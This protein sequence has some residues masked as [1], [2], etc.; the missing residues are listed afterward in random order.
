MLVGIAAVVVLANAPY[1]LHIFDGN[2][3]GPRSQLTDHGLAGILDG[4]PT[5]DPN[6]GFTSQAL[7]HLAAQDW[8]HLQ[9]PWW[10]PYEGAGTALAGEMQSAA[11]FPPTLLLALAN[12]QIYEHVLF[13][14]VAGW[15]TYLL[16][17]RL[18]LRPCACVAGAIAFALNGTFA[19]LGN[20]AANPVALLPVLL[21]GIELAY[22]ATTAAKRGG[23]W[24]IAVAVALS[25]YAGFPE[26]AYIDG[27]FAAGWF[28]WRAAGA[29]GVDRRA[30]AL[31]GL[32][33]ALV[34]ALL[35]APIITA[36]ADFLHVGYTAGFSAHAGPHLEIQ[37]LPA[38]VLPYVYG[39]I[40]GLHDAKG[41]STGVWGGVGGYLTMSLVVFG[42]LGLVSHGRR[43]L[44][45]LLGVWLALA[46]ARMYGEP[47]ELGRVLGVLPGMS[48]VVFYRYATPAVE[49]AA[50]VLLALGVD[51]LA[52]LP[53][54]RRRAL[55]A[56]AFGLT[57]VVAAG[58]EARGL[59]IT[60]VGEQ[61]RDR[62]FRAAVVVGGA[63]VVLGVAAT[64]SRRPRLR[65]GVACGLVV[66]ETLAAFML[67]ELSAPRK[68]NTNFAAVDYLRGQ[69][70]LQRV[71]TLGPLQPNYG[72]YF[73]VAEINDDDLPI[74]KRWADYVS[75]SL[76]PTIKPLHFYGISNDPKT[77]K[78]QLPFEE[79]FDNLDGY[80]V[81]GVTFVI[82][83]AYVHL[84]GR[85]PKTF[86]KVFSARDATVYKVAGDEPY[87]TASGGAC[88]IVTESRQQLSLVCTRG[89][90]LIRR[91][92]NLPGWTARVD[93]ARTAI[94]AADGAF[95]AVDLSA[96]SH[97]VSFVYTPP[98]IRW[99]Y[100]AFI[101]GIAWLV[102][103]A[104]GR[105]LPL[106]RRRRRVGAALVAPDASVAAQDGVE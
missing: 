73:G 33:G 13:E 47:P 88:H 31:K 16:L 19:W 102:L 14:L 65:I 30:F 45:I 75:S 15:A 96:G 95:Q 9:I 93:G 11:L 7:G 5:I 50:V 27:V 55:A 23:W 22:A 35:A 56:A 53:S 70:G 59:V 79:L 1:L 91:E 72:S 60:L 82:T 2:P 89:S 43:G 32:A 64:L 42:G 99:A 28:I 61:T 97:R 69:I 86:T 4:M 37:A 94:H 101:A 40:F 48:S 3:L 90:V 46:I 34:G 92:T 54:G 103:G 51:C 20:A 38:L 8:F 41:L 36:F 104:R 100:A 71:A 80:R 58:L 18:E 78:S 26:T 29:D 84:A 83:P 39:S 98:H 21:L 106:P 49:M 25:I 105:R 52:A 81:A 77:P 24:L 74:P 63:V 87:F 17:R 85:N 57:V 6:I 10:N 76:D 67:P 62:Y 66:L 12:G 68:V 44:R